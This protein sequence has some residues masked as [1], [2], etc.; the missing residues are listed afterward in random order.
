MKIL[1]GDPKIFLHILFHILISSY[2]EKFCKYLMTFS[3]SNLSL[4][5]ISLAFLMKGVTLIIPLY[6]RDFEW[7]PHL[8]MV[9][10]YHVLTRQCLKK[11]FLTSNDFVPNHSSL[12][13]SMVSLYFRFEEAAADQLLFR[14]T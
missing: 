13:E 2:Y 12:L 9:L 8:E 7:K 3:T 14:R 1:N 10:I 5:K 6:L 4:F 11:V